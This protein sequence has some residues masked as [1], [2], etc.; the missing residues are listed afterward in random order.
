MNTS[1]KCLLG[2]YFIGVIVF[3]LIFV[4]GTIFFFIAP[5][6]IIGKTCDHSYKTDLVD[7]LYALNI[8][9]QNTFCSPSCECYLN[10]TAEGADNL[11][12]ILESNDLS[13][14]TT[15]SSRKTYQSC[16]PAD[17]PV[18]PN[19]ILMTA[20]EEILHCS[21]WCSNETVRFRRFS[22]IS[23][24]MTKCTFIFNDRMPRLEWAL[25]CKI[26]R[27]FDNPRKALRIR[28]FTSYSNLSHKYGHSMLHLFSSFS[29]R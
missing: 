4:A 8:E 18:A 24:C 9:A 25:L 2:I 17:Q 27:F 12:E 23:S 16:L 1:G 15:N 28:L 22:D 13:Y 5:E 29:S 26:R 14:T 11:Q 3:F 19:V 6:T 20:L 10:E 21:G 7:E